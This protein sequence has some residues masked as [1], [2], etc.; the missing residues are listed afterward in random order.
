MRASLPIGL[1]RRYHQ[2]VR[3]VTHRYLI[4]AFNIIWFDLSDVLTLEQSLFIS[5]SSWK[6]RDTC[7][8]PSPWLLVAVFRGGTLADR[9]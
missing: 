3:L 9:S 8:E 7:S 2:P 6:T 5:S 4:F 1:N